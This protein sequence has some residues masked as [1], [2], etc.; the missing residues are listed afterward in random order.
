MK[1]TECSKIRRKSQC[2]NPQVCFHSPLPHL[3]SPFQGEVLVI[4]HE[5]HPCPLLRGEGGYDF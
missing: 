2:F 5:P 1:T 4:D 3:T